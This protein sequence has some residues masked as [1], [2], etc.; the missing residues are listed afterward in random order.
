M[1]AQHLIRAHHAESLDHFHHAGQ[2]AVDTLER[3][4]DLS[5]RHLRGST[6]THGQRAQAVAEG[7]QLTPVDVDAAV[8]TFEAS[9]H[10]LTESYGRWIKLLEAQMQLMQ[11]TTHASLE[12]LQRWMPSGT[13]FAVEAVGLLGDAAES[14]SELAADAS[15]AVARSAEAS[16]SAPRAPARRRTVAAKAG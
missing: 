13:E 2:L 3:L 12:D 5:L 9:L 11:R 15:V 6:D 16:V 14:A 1:I 4:T 10:V 7:E 8:S